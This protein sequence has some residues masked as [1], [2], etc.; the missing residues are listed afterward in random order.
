MYMSSF[1]GNQHL[2]AMGGADILREV[3]CSPVGH[4]LL[5]AHGFSRLPFKCASASTAVL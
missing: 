4:A 5:N 2:T 3:T 1:G